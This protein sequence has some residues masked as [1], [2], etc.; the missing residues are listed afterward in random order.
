MAS[1]PPPHTCYLPSCDYRTVPGLSAESQL[2]ELDLH[3]K[4]AHGETTVENMRRQPLNLARPTPHHGPKKQRKSKENPQQEGGC[5]CL[6]DLVLGSLSRG[7][8]L[9]G[10]LVARN[11]ILVIGLS[12]ILA[13]ILSSG[14]AITWKEETDILTLWQ[15]QVN[16]QQF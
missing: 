16:D 2:K 6:Q 1:P 5:A 8:S 11:P 12:V 7:F 13:I 9:H 14:V 4:Y 15:P 10:R 3:M